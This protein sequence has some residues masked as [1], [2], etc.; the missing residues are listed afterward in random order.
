MVLCNIFVCKPQGF[1]DLFGAY[2]RKVFPQTP[3]VTLVFVAQCY[4]GNKGNC[5]EA[6]YSPH[7]IKIVQRC[8][9]RVHWVDFL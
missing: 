5:Y 1:M 3:S 6:V 9:T 2:I 7:V 4:S 8:R